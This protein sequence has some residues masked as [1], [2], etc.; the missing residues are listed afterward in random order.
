MGKPHHEHPR[1]DQRPGDRGVELAEAGPGLRA[2]RMGLRHRDLH[3]VQAKL[4]R[5]RATS[6]DTVT[7]AHVAPC[8]AT[9]RCQ[10][11]RAVCRCLRGTSRP[12]SSQESI[13]S[14]YASIAGRVRRAYALRGGGTA[15]ASAWR[16][17]RRCT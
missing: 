16:T 9:S 14:T 10:T 15:L 11:G 7:S 17:V 12:A 8:S 1:L 3:P 13:T 4:D 5:R 2:R 6:R